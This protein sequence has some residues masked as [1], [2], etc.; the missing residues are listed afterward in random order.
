MPKKKRRT[1]RKKHT[2]TTKSPLYKINI[3][4]SILLILVLIAIAGYLTVDNGAKESIK[5]QTSQKKSY[6]K[7]KITEYFGNDI[8]FEEHTDELTKVYEDSGEI[9]DVKKSELESIK[10]YLKE[11]TD[12]DDKISNVIKK[13][14]KE[15]KKAQE[16]TVSDVKYKKDTRPK[17]A[18]IIDDVTFANQVKKIISI[19][20]KVNMAFLPPT[21]GHRNSAKI[22]QNLENYMVHLPLQASSSRYEEQNTLHIGDPLE[23]IEKRIVYLKKIYPKAKYI[24]N[25]TGSKFTADHESMDKL[26]KILKKH[27]YRF[28]DSRTTSKTTAKKYA[29]KYGVPFLSRNIF[30]DNKQDFH[31]IQGQLKKA[32][33]IAEKT[34]S[35][36]AIGHPHKITIEVLKKSK[37]LLN[38]INLVYVN[39]LKTL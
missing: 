27:D 14:E 13:I 10:K 39:E 11:E 18:I 31:Y 5:T 17:L 12:K 9:K 28:I 36:I 23:T 21:D 6:V 37:K 22:A 24:N 20:Y 26:L 30:L 2:K 4:L 3:I 8:L 33:R 25:H 19:G 32:I 1:S 15:L 29:L 34:G 35:A 7:E 38:G 16:K